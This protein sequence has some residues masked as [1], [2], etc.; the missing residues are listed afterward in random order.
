MSRQLYM[1]RIAESYNS[2]HSWGHFGSRLHPLLGSWR[3]DTRH[4]PRLQMTEGDPAGGTAHSLWTASGAFSLPILVW[5]PLFPHSHSCLFF[6]FPSPYLWVLPASKVMRG[7][8]NCF[9]RNRKFDFFIM[10]SHSRL[11]EKKTL[12]NQV[13]EN[14]LF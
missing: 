6:S 12:E 4:Q 3:P 7:G 13:R 11:W 9:G 10:M 1:R 14:K 5:R 2:V 8:L